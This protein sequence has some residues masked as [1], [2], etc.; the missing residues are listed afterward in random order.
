MKEEALKLA[1]ELDNWFPDTNLCRYSADMIRKL[2]AE[3]DKYRGKNF[4]NIIIDELD[5]PKELSRSDIYGLAMEAG[6]MLST[7]YGQEKDK[8]MPVSDGETLVKFVDLILNK[9]S[10]K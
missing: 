3:L 4:D 7:Q 6:F 10:D 9:S 8:L 2:V 1:D 5:K